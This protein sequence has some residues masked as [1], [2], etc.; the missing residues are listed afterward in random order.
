MYAMQLDKISEVIAHFIGM[1]EISVEEARQLKTYS[2]FKIADAE[3]E[4][5]TDLP[6]TKV[7]IKAPYTLDDFD[8]HVPYMGVKPDLVLNTVGSS[9]WYNPVDVHMH[10]HLN[11]ANHHFHLPHL[12]GGSGGMI[13]PHVEPPGAV[14]AYM[15]QEI[16][17]SDNDYVSAG[18][19]GLTFSRAID[20]SAQIASLMSKAAEVSPID[21][22]SLLGTPDDMKAGIV[23]IGERIAA[24]PDAPEGDANVFVLRSDEATG[25]ISGTYV[26]GQ[27]VDQADAPKAED[28]LNILKEHKQDDTT[29]SDGPDKDNYNTSPD[30]SDFMSGWGNGLLN[31]GVDVE[32]GGNTLINSAV[33][34]N[35]WVASSVVAA[36]GNSY[37][38]NAIIQINAHCDT[39]VVSSSLNGWAHSNVP[40]EAFNIA[41]FKHMDPSAGHE[42]PT[43]ADGFPAAWV[44]TQVTGD[45]LITNWIQ[46][47]SFITD[48]DTTIL[49]SSGVRTSVG[50]GDNT[51]IN[52][53]S[54]SELGHYYDLIIIGGNFYDA[55]VIHQ[56]NFLIDNDLIGAVDGFST[57]GPGSYSTAGNLL[58][59]DATIINVGGQNHYEALPTSYLQAAQGLAAGNDAGPGGI[60]HDEAFAGIGAL[61][62]LYISGDLLNVNYVSQTN[63]LGDSDQVALAMNQFVAHPEAEWTV[64]TG[65]NQVANFAGIVDV[66][67]TNKTYVGGEHYSHE[68]LIQADIISCDPELGGQNPDAL[69]NEAV[70]FLAD[71]AA[72]GDSPIDHPIV[73]TPDH[74]Q[75]DGVH[76]VLG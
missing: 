44:V 29:A 43:Q 8:P 50:T 19:H 42:A 22:V 55:N 74:V 56:V 5:N 66:D 13:L 40:D 4:D 28:H 14:A 2:D 47:Y 35:N 30:S 39:D 20:D 76:T 59:N 12:P 7:T 72:D 24:Y 67:G 27:L 73:P 37:E 23:T 58:W 18:G 65:G 70:A 49:S 9:F 48:N 36:V 57:S 11:P 31:P 45:L 63:V 33:L 38:I 3:K 16:R 61:R 25:P 1:F 60:L 54:L 46:Q 71:D 52:D 41:T 64:T 26:N 68:I 17:L 21:D 62:V 34:T 51:A 6:S 10:G 75:A 69:V 32:T 53:V 15:N